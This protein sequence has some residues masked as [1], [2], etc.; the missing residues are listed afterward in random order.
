MRNKINFEDD[1][2]WQPRLQEIFE[3]LAFQMRMEH[4]RRGKEQKEEAR[5]L[6]RWYEQ[7]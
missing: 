4:E 7:S 6:E 2:Q 1:A 5:L 3:R